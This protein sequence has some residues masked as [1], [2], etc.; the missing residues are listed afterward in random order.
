MRFLNLFILVMALFIVGCGTSTKVIGSWQAD[1]SKTYHFDKIAII[2]IAAIPE[3]RKIIEEKIEDLLRSKGINADGGL[4]FLPPNAT[5]ENITEEILF[6]FLKN[7]RVDAVLTISLRRINKSTTYVSGTY[8][9]YPWNDAPFGD[10]YGQMKNVFY[11]P[12]YTTSSAT[13]FLESNL[14]SFP[15]EK[16]LWS[17]Q[18]ES[19]DV[20]ELNIFAETVAKAVVT[21]LLKRKVIE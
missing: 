5:Y 4:E 1:S 21:D 10:Y 7:E 16:L 6:G 8:Y 17:A 13:V 14:Y 12:G 15:D 20:T 2:G 9:Y 11:A 3:R 18:T 19:V